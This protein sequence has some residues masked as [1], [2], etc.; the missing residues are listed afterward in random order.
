MAD[1]TGV[2]LPE[3]N[4]P[5]ALFATFRISRPE[6][7]MDCV[8]QRAALV[9]G[10]E[11]LTF[12]STDWAQSLREFPR[13]V[14]L[15]VL[16]RAEA[17]GALVE[18]LEDEGYTRGG[19]PCGHVLGEWSTLP[20]GSVQC[21]TQGEMGQRVVHVVSLKVKAEQ[22]VLSRV[23]GSMCGTYLTGAGRVVSL[24]PRLTFGSRRWWIPSDMPGRIRGEMSRKYA[25]WREAEAEDVWE[26]EAPFRTARDKFCWRMTFDRT[27]TITRIE[28]PEETR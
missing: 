19:D 14:T 8:Q 26:V 27:G 4:T 12:V 22:A 23:Y 24:F 6:E 5:A 13:A 16:C 25:G 21:L 9:T 15:D 10:V 2:S 18:R 20:E 28:V 7:F 11:L 1:W 3:G 17:A